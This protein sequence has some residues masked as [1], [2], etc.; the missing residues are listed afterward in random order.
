MVAETKV[1]TEIGNMYIQSQTSLERGR[2]TYRP[3]EDRT[4]ELDRNLG[5]PWPA[6]KLLLDLRGQNQSRNKRILKPR[7]S[8]DHA[9][10]G[11]DL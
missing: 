6:R 1:W 5:T 3:A 7:G 9:H 10:S 2:D 11:N 4:Q 8:S